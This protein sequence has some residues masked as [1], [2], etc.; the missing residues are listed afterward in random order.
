MDGRVVIDTNVL[1][2]YPDIFE[3]NPETTFVICSLVAE[4]LDNQIKNERGNNEL[5]YKARMAR[6]AIKAAGNKEYDTRVPAFSLPIGWDK[7]KND[8]IIIALSRDLH[9]PLITN[10]LAMQMKADSIG[11]ECIEWESDTFCNLYKGYTEVT[12]DEYEMSV[13]Y[14]CP[15]NKWDLLNNEYLIIKDLEGNVVDKQRWTDDKGFM[16]INTKGFKSV[17]FGDIKPKDVY[18]MCAIDSLHNMDFTLLLGVAGSAKTLLS[19]GWIM[20]NLQS[21][22]ISKAI[23]IFPV[24]KL[25]NNRELGYYSGDRNQKLLQESLGGILSSKL[26]DMNMVE[27]LI[28]QGKILLIPSSDIR[29]IEV[30]S[31]D[32][33]YVTEAQNTDAYTMRTILQRAKEGCKIIVEGDMLEQTDIKCNARQNGMFRAIEVFKGSKYFSCVKLKNTYRSPISEIANAI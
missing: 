29:G 22:K 30:S 17:Y 28:N 26:G 3:K 2:D 18:Q 9:L 31:S 6:N 19:L 16:P 33:L 8:N 4:E 15:V 1:L 5:A 20:Q 23:I 25:K 14:E 10:D 24:T 7:N 13:H 11:V 12:L 27:T 21:S 32:C